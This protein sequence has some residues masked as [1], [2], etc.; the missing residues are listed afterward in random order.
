[1]QTPEQHIKRERAT[2]NICSNEGLL[3]IRAT[4]YLAAMGKNGFEKI[5]NL[6]FQKAHYA[7]DQITK[8]DGYELAFNS[9]PFFR[10]FAIRCT[11]AKVD[12]VI[13]QLRAVGILA[14][15]KLGR[16]RNDLNDCLLVAVTEKRTKEQIDKFVEALA[17]VK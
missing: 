7:A 1:M 13:A 8:L 15:I 11:R 10:E 5:S 12:D 14:G 4:I 6:C 17:A 9:T 2:S 16:W 3:A